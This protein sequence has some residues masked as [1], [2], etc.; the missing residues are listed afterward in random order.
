MMS[1]VELM[2]CPLKSGAR[3]PLLFDVLRSAAAIG[4]HAK[5]IVEIKAGQNL[6]S[7]IYVMHVKCNFMIIQFCCN[8]LKLNEVAV[9]IVNIC[10]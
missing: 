9:M 10:K 8:V 2:N 4:E 1:I 7:S 5:M 3:P 6:Y